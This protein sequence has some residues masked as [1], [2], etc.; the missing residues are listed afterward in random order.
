M[1]LDTVLFSAMSWNQRCRD[2]T[3]VM[4]LKYP[5]QL[6]DRAREDYSAYLRVHADRIARRTV[7]ERNT[8]VLS[9][10]C[11]KGLISRGSIIKLLDY[12]MSLSASECTALLLEYQSKLDWH[13]D[14]LLEEL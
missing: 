8:D 10:L 14:P 11:E 2:K 4:R 13:G 9:Y 1:K 6:S 5:F 7:W 12:S 3:A